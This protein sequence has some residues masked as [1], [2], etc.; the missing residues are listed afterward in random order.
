MIISVGQLRRIIREVL[1]ESSVAAA[2]SAR[3]SVGN[4]L[5]PSMT[6]REQIGRISIPIDK[7]DHE[8]LSSHLEEPEEDP[9]D[10]WGPVPPGAPNPHATPD[11]Y[12]NDFNIVKR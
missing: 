4:A 12:T 10:C 9:E 3:P 8:E 2:T 5:A 7:D 11:F 1:K 6:D